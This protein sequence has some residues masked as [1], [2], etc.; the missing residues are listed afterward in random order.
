[1]CWG[2]PAVLVG[3][4][5]DRGI[6]KVDF[7][8]GIVR[9]VLIGITSDTLRKGD[10]VIVHAGVIISTI[11]EKGLTE[12]YSMLSSLLTEIGEGE[13]ETIKSHYDYIIGISKR[14]KSG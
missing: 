3:I 11:D 14:L 8:D 10:I 2:V 1:M 5:E 9:E 7:G 12:M 6:A 4:E 13:D